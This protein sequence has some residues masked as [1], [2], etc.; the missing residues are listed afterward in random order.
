MHSTALPAAGY[1]RCPPPPSSARFCPGAPPAAAGQV[2]CPCCCAARCPPLLPACVA[3][4][5]R[6]GVRLC[7][8]IRHIAAKRTPQPQRCSDADIEHARPSTPAF[9]WRLNLELLGQSRN[10]T[11]WQHRRQQH[12]PSSAARAP[13]RPAALPPPCRSY[14][15]RVGRTGRAGR[16]GA[17]I[18]LFAPEDAGFRAQLEQH[19]QGKR[20]ER[21]QLGPVPLQQDEEE[22]QEEV[23]VWLKTAALPSW[24]PLAAAAAWVLPSA[25]AALAAHPPPHTCPRHLCCLRMRHRPSCRHG[26]TALAALAALA[27]GA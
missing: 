16:S 9:P 21:Q 20:Q 6:A 10:V 13:S 18:T 11:G 2:A 3:S 17:A 4:G 1:A 5:W 7:M 26:S 22:Q 23:G 27:G 8:W 15:H 12:L 24:Q 14:V 25:A 19:L